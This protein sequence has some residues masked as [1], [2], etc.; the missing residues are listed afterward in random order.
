MRQFNQRCGLLFK[1]GSDDLKESYNG[2]EDLAAKASLWICTF[3]PIPLPEHTSTSLGYKVRPLG[4]HPIHYFHMMFSKEI[5][6]LILRKTNHYSFTQFPSSRNLRSH[7]QTWLDISREELD[8]FLGLVFHMGIVKIS[9][10]QDYWHIDDLHNQPVFRSNMTRDGLFSILQALHFV[11]NPREDK[12]L[13][14]DESLVMWR[15]RLYFRQ[16]IKT[17]KHKYGIKLDAE[18]GG[19]F[20]MQKVTNE[21]KRDY[22]HYGHAVY[23]DSYYNSL[24]LTQDLLL[25]CSIGDVCESNWRFFSLENTWRRRQM[26]QKGE[27]K[28]ETEAVPSSS[29]LS[30]KRRKGDSARKREEVA[31]LS[32]QEIGTMLEYFL[33]EE[34]LGL[35]KLP[36]GNTTRVEEL[37]EEDAA[38][39]DSAIPV[40]EV[41][42]P[43]EGDILWFADPQVSCDIVLFTASSGLKTICIISQSSVA[44]CPVI[45]FLVSY[46]LC[47][48]FEILVKVN[49]FYRTHYIK[50]G[51][52]LI[53]FGTNYGI[54]LYLLC[55]P[56]G[57]FLHQ[58]VYLGS[59]DAELG[60]KGHT[61]KV[62]FWSHHWVLSPSN[63][64]TCV[65]LTT[66]IK[67]WASNWSTFTAT[68]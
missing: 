67:L 56:N 16:Y 18:L 23:M 13:C 34:S 36:K 22:F 27:R 24:K 3:S 50:L 29:G 17:K 52:Y 35:K 31:E 45:D 7:S 32:K 46:E 38:E 59:R 40:G 44:T 12:N 64:L 53:L 41:L 26:E 49:D 21:L 8:V 61:Q 20:H 2:E 28:D 6:E 48:S 43:L 11:Q 63:L 19:K 14:I 66:L 4:D 5:Y 9:T 54:K 30:T 39:V 37:S 33:A 68:T 47:I 55:E 42:T 62:E 60:G 58:I 10:F 1:M 65:T 15:G 25:F 51:H 57:L